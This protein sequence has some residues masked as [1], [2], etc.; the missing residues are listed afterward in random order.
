MDGL[1]ACLPRVLSELAPEAREAITLCDLDGITQAEYAQRLGL[2]LAG[3][4]SRVQ[5][6]RRRLR[7]QLA[8]FCQVRLDDDGKVCCFVPRE[9]GQ[10]AEA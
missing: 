4:K 3:A 5:R 7:D 8:K 6:A 1:A 10:G 2:S 9:T